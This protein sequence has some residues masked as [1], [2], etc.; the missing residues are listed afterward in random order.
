MARDQRVEQVTRKKRGAQG[1]TAS[2]VG[3][4][5]NLFLFGFKFIA[6]SVSG[7]ISIRGDAFNNLSDAASAV[8]SLLSFRLSTKP[9][10]KQ[11]PFGHARTE[12]LGTSVVAVIILVIAYELFVESI[13]QIREPLPVEVNWLIVTS[14]I[15]SIMVKLGLFFYYHRRA[16]AIRS[17]LLAATARDSISD[18]AATSVVLI[19]I[20]IHSQTGIHT[21]GWLGI[22]VA[23]FIAY[24]GFTI[25]IETFNRIMGQRP[26]PELK[27]EI[28]EL[29]LAAKEILGLHDLVIH[30]YGPGRQFATVHVEVDAR[31]DMLD[32]HEIIDTI[33][34]R[35]STELG[36]ELV[37]HMD[38]IVLDDPVVNATR[39]EVALLVSSIDP[40]LS[41]H[42]F[43]MV[44]RKGIAT[45]I[46]DVTIPSD[47]DEAE[48]EDNRLRIEAEIEARNENYETV[49]IL[50]RE[51]T[52]S[53]PGN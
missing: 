53:L 26:D 14:L 8:V 36:V 30:D 34:R 39:T 44:K 48:A 20:V 3:I 40:R 9:A 45:L 21:D 18:V 12:Y 51:Y 43:R 29:V 2:L 10:D 41:M 27:R 22:L 33:E 28:A 37:I 24:Q 15:I 17:D 6:G 46:F 35:A 23:L 4:F 11:H 31:N 5:V 47:M 38:P 32:S 42:D 49:I 13:G 25:L 16:K 50:D 52:T 19:G 1:R 7:S